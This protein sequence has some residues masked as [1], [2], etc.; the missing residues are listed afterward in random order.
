MK[1]YYR[2]DDMRMSYRGLLSGKKFAR[3]KAIKHAMDRWFKAKWKKYVKEVM[4]CNED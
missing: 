4:N 1:S 3:R 2:I